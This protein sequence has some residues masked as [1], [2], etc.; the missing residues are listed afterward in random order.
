M[1]RRGATAQ[2][3]LVQDLKRKRLFELT[4]AWTQTLEAYKNQESTYSYASELLNACGDPPKL[5]DGE[6]TTTQPFVTN[7]LSEMNDK[8]KDVLT[9]FADLEAPGRVS[10]GTRKPDI[11]FL[12]EGKRGAGRITLIGEVKGYTTGNGDF[13]DEHVGEILDTAFDLMDLQREREFLY[14]FITDGAR[15]QYFKI[16]RRKARVSDYAVQYSSVYVYAEKALQVC[17]CM[18]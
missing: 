16:D 9:S 8:M 13:S 10:F 4:T 7:L 17:S 11:V 5:G 15:F 12:D 6:K 1:T 14:A 2:A 18:K 3:E